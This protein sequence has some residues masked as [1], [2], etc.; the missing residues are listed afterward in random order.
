M[1]D[2]MK[3]IEMR[4]RR[5]ADAQ[6]EI[7]RHG[8]VGRKAWIFEVPHARRTHAC[9]G[10]LV[11]EPGRGPAAE[12]G[13]NRLMQRR[14]DLEQ[15]EHGADNPSGPPRGALCWM[16]PTST[17]MAIANTAGSNPRKSR[18]VHH[19]RANDRSARPST[20]KNFHPSPA[21]NFLSI[22]LCDSGAE[23]WFLIH[24]MVPANMVPVQPPCKNAGRSIAETR[25]AKLTGSPSPSAR[26]HLPSRCARRLRHWRDVNTATPN[27]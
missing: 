18:T 16:A 27:A 1:P 14:Q 23:A 10:Q 12:I 17:P 4:Q 8:E 22:A 21:C 6:V 26:L 5:P 7:P 20:P 2:A 19:A 15:N 11:V 13:P 3:P 25:A 9:G 24:Q